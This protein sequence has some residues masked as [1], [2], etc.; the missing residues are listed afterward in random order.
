MK[1][2]AKHESSGDIGCHVHPPF[3]CVGLSVPCRLVLDLGDSE[4]DLLMHDILPGRSKV[5]LAEAARK[6]LSSCRMLLGLDHVEDTRRSTWPAG[7]QSEVPVGLQEA[8]SNTVD[9]LECLDVRYGHLA[10]RQADYTAVF[11]MHGVDVMYTSSS[12]DGYLESEVCPR[13]VPWS[14]DFC[15]RC[16]VGLL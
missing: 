9:L 10:R 3:H 1:T 16:E 7:V 13:C 15:K 12:H 2:L 5:V 8:G 14:R 11:L 4:V 6:H